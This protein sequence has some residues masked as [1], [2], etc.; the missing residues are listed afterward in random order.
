[1]MSRF[2]RYID[3]CFHFHELLPLFTDTRKKPQLSGVSVF[4][5]VLA[6]FACNRTSL[7]SL[8][9]D[10]IH[11]PSRLRGLVGPRPP[12][13]DTLG[14]VYALADRDGLRQI[15]VQMHHR[16][17]RNKTLA[18][19]DDLKIAAVDGHEFFKS[20]KRCCAQ[21][22]QRIL[23][24]DGEEVVEY[25]H[26]GVVCH[27][28]EH[29]LA[30][31]LDVELLRPGEG[32]ETAA[33]RLLQRVFA[34]YPRY[35]D[36]VG[37]DALYF[38]APFINFCL[39][40][41][42]H[43]LVVV[44]GD[45]RLLLQDAQGLFAQQPA[46]TWQDR[47]RTVQYWDAEGF[48][49]CEGVKQPLR[50]VHTV[51]AVR[52]RERVARQWQEKE[53]TSSWYWATTLSKRQLSTRRVWQAGHGRWDAEND[54]FNT[55]SMHWGLDHC[56][57]HDPVAIVNF[58]LTLFLAYVLLQCFWQRNVKAPLRKKIGTLLGLAEELRRS[59]GAGMQAPWSKQLARAP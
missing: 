10:L 22:Q 53:E 8:E 35:F 40:H 34:N 7:N 54:C 19:G 15:L 49:T 24:I 12:S 11:F 29:R 57:K 50:V 18:D 59:L 20:R 26:Q 55:L 42:K 27:L 43:A 3:K 33:K 16:L 41:H 5:S 48:T 32:E 1:M 30:V 36:V 46:Q 58:V 28:I 17:K 45:Q 13:I 56:F 9:K 4:A 44:K 37:G 23:T 51:E 14:R 21:C 52:R 31:P 39:D 25:Y 47:Q 2:C 38:D 6:L